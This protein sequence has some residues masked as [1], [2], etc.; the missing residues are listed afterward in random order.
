MKL[1]EA[2]AAIKSLENGPEL[3]SA[4]ET[5]I[6]GLKTKNFEIIGEKRN[7][8]NRAT[9]LESTVLA[10]AKIAGVEGDLESVLTSLEPKVR[11]SLQ[12]LSSVEAK[13]TETETRA[14]EAQTKL[15][16]LERKAKLSDVAAAAGANPAALEKLLGDRFDELKIEG[17]GESRVVKLGDKVLRDAIDGDENLKIFSASLFPTQET[18]Q[19]ANK[20]PSGKPANTL[21]NGSPNGE[22]PKEEDAA[23]SYLESTYGGIKALTKTNK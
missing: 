11:E 20:L 3:V 5:E 14:T 18:K 13:L 4:I 9:T 21:P 12:K 22:Q 10:I 17:E 6:E 7:A 16:G 2:L 23:L 19:P 1:G 8:T 15:Q